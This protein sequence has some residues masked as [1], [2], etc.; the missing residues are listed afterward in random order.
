MTDHTSVTL[1]DELPV[2]VG[3]ENV[4]GARQ[5]KAE[6]IV[7]HLLGRGVKFW[8]DK[9]HKAYATFTEDS[10]IS[11]YAVEGRDFSLKVRDIWLRT[12]STLPKTGRSLRSVTKHEM[13][14]VVNICETE[15][16]A[17]EV[18]RPDVRVVEYEGTIYL[19]LGC[20]KWSIVRMT[21][22][23]WIVED[24]ADV[25]LIRSPGM[26]ALPVPKHDPNALTNLRE[27][28]NLE[29]EDDFKA[30]VGW[31]VAALYHKG[32][33]PVLALSGGQGTGKT[34][35]ADILLRLVDP[36]IGNLH[37]GTPSER[38][39]F[40]AAGN[41]RVVALDN[42]SD[43]PA[44]LADALCRIAS[45]GA[46]RGR[47]LYT[48]A[49]ESVIRVAR[50]IIF[51][52]IPNLL[53]RGDLADR[54][55]SL[56]LPVIPGHK[57]RPV[58]EIW[59]RFDAA[60]PGI[61]ALLLDGIVTALQRLPTLKRSHL[62]RMADF[63]LLACAA[64]PAFDWTE[65]EMFVA[66]ESNRQETSESVTE[67]DLFAEAVI[68]LAKEFGPGG[69]AGTAT[70]LRARL[71][72]S[73][74]GEARKDRS[75]PNGPA[76]FS[77]FLRRL[78]G[79]LHL[80]GVAVRWTRKG[81]KGPRLITIRWISD[82]EEKSAGQDGPRKGQI[83]IIKRNPSPAMQPSQSS[84]TSN[85]GPH[86]AGHTSPRGSGPTRIPAGPQPAR[87]AGSNGP[88]RKSVQGLG[89][90]LPAPPKASKGDPVQ[91]SGRIIVFRRA[92]PD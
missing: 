67:D 33:Y 84:S 46:R 56:V 55:L 31:L 71:N 15:A 35:T 28:L 19:D 10:Q 76:Q 49:G 13:T 92:K 52:G 40:I 4:S 27:L 42:L 11:R 43:I 72:Q 18:R 89:L 77:G 61:L 1:T 57:R 17:G 45:G 83:T 29:N 14:E 70:E 9:Y 44:G 75:W 34:T 26:E 65:E 23:G 5:T 2:D 32:P 62:P 22:D 86:D 87:Q 25:P 66:L 37:G 7:A 79:P 3:S 38:D 64:A 69:L 68:E 41:N 59:E 90:K 81:G 6:Q 16:F 24:Q 63:T 21:A 54:A 60:A 91:P 50:P 85:A 47:Q 20:E 53:L 8:R 74:S 30:V 82:T 58:S 80:A 73:V 51:T 78:E 39:L 48:D 36:N 88:P 12:S